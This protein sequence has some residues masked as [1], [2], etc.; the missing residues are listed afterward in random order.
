M[1]K[2]VV[3][4]IALLAVVLL[5]GSVGM[6]KKEV[7]KPK[8]IYFFV[9]TTFPEPGTG[10]KQFCDE[11]KKQTGIELKV[12]QPV[13]N[14][15]YEKMRLAFASGDIPDVVES[16]ELNYSQYAMEGAYID[17]GKYI[18]SSA[19]F[20]K[21]DKKVWDS[22]KV[23]GKI[24]GVPIQMGGA[25][26]TY[27]R[28]DW[29][30]N[31]GMKDPTTWTEYL[32]LMR[33]FTHNDPDKN[34][35][36][37]TYAVTAPGPS[38]DSPVS[39]ANNYYRD[40]WQNS[41][42]EFM[43]KRGKWVDGFAQKEIK[44]ALERLRLI[45]QEKL[46]DPEIFTNKTSTCREKFNSGKCGIFTYWAGYWHPR[47]EIDLQTNLGPKAKIHGI[48]PIKGSYYAI[49]VPQS[50]SITIKCKNPEGV[51]KY[52][53]EYM[54]DGGKGQMLFSHGVEGVHW[55]VKDGMK[56]KLPQLNNSKILSTKAYSTPETPI[57]PWVNPIP[58]DKRTEAANAIAYN[59][60]NYIQ[61]L[62][63]PY[64]DSRKKIEDE[65][66]R[67]KNDCIAK[68]LTG[69]KTV[70][71]AHA[72]YMKKYAELGIQKVLNEMNAGK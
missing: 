68:V 61:M 2:N 59:P 19:V 57:T 53:L 43:L 39:L 3:R 13:H 18:K 25:P 12:V 24:Y 44:P 33:A 52:F 66:S 41:N 36:N 16:S 40:F 50:N 9:D 34:G 37:D 38:S 1:K 45:Y 14:Q 30:E 28:T 10:Q 7:P 46:I 67:A 15:Y 26:I 8:S 31:L 47:L 27:I 56:V 60:K 51:F 64:P 71:Q 72:D 11:Y 29:L 6:A 63:Q 35:K 5:V 62:I 69:A 4:I 17:L 55:A 22:A 54:H 49:R 32:K 58:S 42:P 21:V 70:E 65:V 20:K 48:P 23:K